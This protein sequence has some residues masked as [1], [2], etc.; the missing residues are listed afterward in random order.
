[1]HYAGHQAGNAQGSQAFSQHGQS[2]AAQYSDVPP[3]NGSVSPALKNKLSEEGIPEMKLL[4]RK[5][6][7]RTLGA[8][9]SLE[10]TE[11]V[12]LLVKARQLYEVL[13]IFPSHL[14]NTLNKLFGD[15]PQQGM[16]QGGP[17]SQQQWT[18]P[19]TEPLTEPLD[20]DMRL[21]ACTACAL[22]TANMQSERDGRS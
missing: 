18:E 10:S 14:K 3:S 19:R 15:V 2:T 20:D 16:Y 13:D 11:R 17:W 6:G 7:I 8:F 22:W 9:Y 4:L 21:T 12:V 5:R 1:M